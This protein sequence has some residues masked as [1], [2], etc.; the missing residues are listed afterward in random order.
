LK[1]LKSPPPNRPTPPPP[2]SGRVPSPSS[3]KRTVPGTAKKKRRSQSP[4]KRPT[5]KKEEADAKTYNGG[6]KTNDQWRQEQNP[7]GEGTVIGGYRT[8]L[9][10]SRGTGG[11]RSLRKT[12]GDIPTPSSE[13][14]D[15]D[16]SNKSATP[17]GSP[18]KTRRVTTRSA[19][20]NVLRNSKRRKVIS[21]SMQS[22]PK[23]SR[24][25]S[26]TPRKSVSVQSNL[27]TRTNSYRKKK[28][29][30]RPLPR[31]PKKEVTANENA[32]D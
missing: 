1:R 10:K 31:V 15:S 24:R 27:N 6:T 7:R 26:S 32:K 18:K 9:R 23:K 3:K 17:P 4:R 16:S 13:S 12:K 11:S 14:S 8:R 29:P 21:K 25:T 28:P 2:R 22:S 30:Q 20:A 19:S 5:P